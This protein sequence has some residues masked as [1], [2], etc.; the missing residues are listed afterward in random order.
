MRYISRDFIGL[1]ESGIRIIF[2]EALKYRDVIHLE[3]GD[4][5]F[6]TPRKIIEYTYKALKKGY[7]HYT[8][9]A[10]LRELRE[11]IAE[12]YGARYGVSIDYKDVVIT[13]GSTEGLFLTILATT[14]YNDEVLIPSPGYPSYSIMVKAARAI[15]KRYTLKREYGFKLSFQ[16][17]KDSISDKTRAI[18]INNP[19]NPTGA[20]TPLDQLEQLVKYA[21]NRDIVVISD[22]VYERI[23]YDRK[24]FP[25]LL[26]LIDRYDNIVVVNSFS[27]AYAMTGWRIGFVISSNQELIRVLTKLQEGIAACAVSAIQ[28]ALADAL[29]DR[30]VEEEVERLVKEYEVRR[31]IVVEILEK[32][33]IDFVKPE[34]AFYVFVDLSK[35]IRDSMDFAL[36]LLERKH[37]AIAPG[38]AFGPGFEGFVRISYVLKSKNRLVEGL[39]RFISYLEEVKTFHEHK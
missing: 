8:H 3:I 39:K 22:E 38:T 27:K 11:A 20:V 4:P 9:N 31:N 12:I 29:R 2:H 23:V 10:G 19:H 25:S 37:V 13:I 17:V 34:G 21:N 7:T 28:K 30:K 24:E 26:K 1:E 36:K 5:E 14:N 15:P 16:E 35:Y 33:N 18:I 6:D 32:A